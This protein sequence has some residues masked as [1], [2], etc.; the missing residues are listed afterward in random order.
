MA[1][2]IGRDQVRILFPTADVNIVELK[3]R[4]ENS[5]ESSVQRYSAVVGRNEQFEDGSF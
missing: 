1:S 2:L 3:R 5:L 4:S